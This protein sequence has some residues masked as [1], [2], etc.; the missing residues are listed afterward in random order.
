[1]PSSDGKIGR[2][3]IGLEPCGERN[4]RLRGVLVFDRRERLVKR[5]EGEGR[6]LLVGI[7]LQ[8]PN[9]SQER[10]LWRFVRGLL[11]MKDIRSNISLYKIVFLDD[12]A[13]G[14]MVARV[15]RSEK[16]TSHRVANRASGL[17]VD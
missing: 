5:C 1:M 12:M 4:S 11:K 8:H 13:F 2:I 15:A 14:K 16:R 3:Y 7:S 17:P 10:T 6:E 9:S